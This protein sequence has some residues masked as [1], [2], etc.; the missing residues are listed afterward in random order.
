MVA[1]LLSLILAGCAS[2]PPDMKGGVIRLINVRQRAASLP[3]IHE[4]EQA[5]ST[6][7]QGAQCAGTEPSNGRGDDQ[8]GRAPTSG[9]LC[10]S[11]KTRPL[12]RSSPMSILAGP[13]GRRLRAHARRQD[14]QVHQCRRVQGCSEGQYSMTQIK[15]T[16]PSGTPP[17]SRKWITT[18]SY[19]SGESNAWS[20]LP[21]GYTATTPAGRR[22]PQTPSS[23]RRVRARNR[24]TRSTAPGPNV[25]PGSRGNGTIV[26]CL[27]VHTRHQCRS[28]RQYTDVFLPSWRCVFPPPVLPR[29]PPTPACRQAVR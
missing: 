29:V 18:W 23:G 8:V 13:R 20:E 28:L 24:A 19:C 16:F 3:P 21:A 2:Q 25:I 4:K 10:L 17:I 26:V 22:I 7:A 15:P 27:A 1:S 14:H 5:R 11:P 6:I 12:T 9:A